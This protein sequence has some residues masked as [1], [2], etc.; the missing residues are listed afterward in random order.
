[1]REAKGADTAE[2]IATRK[3]AEMA[4][5]AGSLLAGSLL[6]GSGW[7]PEPLHAPDQVFTAACMPRIRST[8]YRMV[9]IPLCQ[10]SYNVGL[11]RPEMDIQATLVFRHYLAI[12]DRPKTD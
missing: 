7:L 6:A 11:T 2:R 9:A 3:K 8:A 5:K 10:H 1:M 12:T 4:Q